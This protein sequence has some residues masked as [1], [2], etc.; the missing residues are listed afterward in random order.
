MGLGMGSVCLMGF[1]LII[2]LPWQPVVSDTWFC[3]SSEVTP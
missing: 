3:H 2:L 1:I